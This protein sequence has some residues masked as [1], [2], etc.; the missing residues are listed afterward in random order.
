MPGVRIEAFLA[1]EMLL[2]SGVRSVDYRVEAIDGT[3]YLM[4]IA[5]NQTELQRVIDHARDISYVR[6]VTNWVRIKGEPPPPLPD[7][8]GPD[9]T[10]P[11]QDPTGPEPAAPAA[12]PTATAAS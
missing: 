7:Q 11:T 4:G 9:Q 6:K 5:Q 12:M 10:E 3:L 2:D 8:T 1:V